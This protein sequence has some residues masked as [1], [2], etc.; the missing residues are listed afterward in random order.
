MFIKPL[1]KSLSLAHGRKFQ[2][3]TC[4]M[5]WSPLEITFRL[6]L[7]V[8]GLKHSHAPQ[9]L[10]HNLTQ[11]IG[12]TRFTSSSVLEATSSS[13]S[14]RDSNRPI[15]QSNEK[16]RKPIRLLSEH[17]ITGD[18]PCITVSSLSR[19][20]KHTKSFI[21]R[22]RGEEKNKVAPFGRIGSGSEFLMASSFR[23]SRSL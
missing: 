14:P 22:A 9:E 2:Y 3:Q 16:Y 7:S 15:K 23:A 19:Q 13:F 10:I 6:S 18:C 8:K 17:T 5:R 4:S 12:T 20:G 11:T 21:M 1:T